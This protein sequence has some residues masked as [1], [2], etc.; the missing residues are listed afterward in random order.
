MIEPKDYLNE[1]KKYRKNMFERHAKY[2]L[3]TYLNPWAT[4]IKKINQSGY[5]DLNNDCSGLIY[6]PV[7]ASGC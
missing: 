2:V 1:F 6:M 4:S 7:Q 5:T 3:K